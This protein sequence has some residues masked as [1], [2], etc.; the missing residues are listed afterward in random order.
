MLPLRSQRSREASSWK[1]PPF[2]LVGL[3]GD[4]SRSATGGS[5]DCPDVYLLLTGSEQALYGEEDPGLRA[6]GG[7]ELEGAVELVLYERAND[8]EPRP[9]A[10]AAD[11]AAVVR[12]R[13]DD[14]AVLSSEVDRDVL[15]AVLERVLEELGEHERE[16]SRLLSRQRDLRELGRHLLARDE[17]L[18]EHRSQPVDELAEVD[19]VLAMLRQHLVHRGD[20]ED[21]IH[22][23]LERLA[24][25]DVLGS[26]LEPQERGDC[27]EIVLDAVVDL[28][29]EHT[30]HDGA[31]MLEGD[32][33]VVRDR[34]E[35]RSLVVRE[36][37]VPIADQ[38]ADLPPLPAQRQA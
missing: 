22:G 8:G 7:L 36:R 11:P 15:A 24:R 38:L 29:G 17:P 26:R 32:S 33:R 35:Q 5:H 34:L 10:V 27:L 18:D 20:R 3:H 25:I 4:R 31:P 13:E 23:V 9:S 14:L 21:A 12:D 30:A 37:R 2:A 19:V 16:R 28:L 1:S 6:T